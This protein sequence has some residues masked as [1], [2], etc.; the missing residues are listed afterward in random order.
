MKWNRATAICTTINGHLYLD[1][2]KAYTKSRI[3]AVWVRVYYTYR[4]GIIGTANVLTN[5]R[6]SH[7]VFHHHWKGGGQGVAP[8]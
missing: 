3:H 5:L 7:W 2:F 6:S 1:N 8:V 4:T